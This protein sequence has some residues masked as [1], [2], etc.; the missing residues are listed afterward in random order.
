MVIP[1]TGC[2]SFLCQKV[3]GGVHYDLFDNN[4]KLKGL[5]GNAVFPCMLCCGAQKS[6]VILYFL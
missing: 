5:S 1:S 3:E 4:V 6:Y 2:C